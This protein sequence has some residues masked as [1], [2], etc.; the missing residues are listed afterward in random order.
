MIQYQG[1]L[2]LTEKLQDNICKSKYFK[3]VVLVKCNEGCEL[4]QSERMNLSVV[5]YTVEVNSKRILFNMQGDNI[6]KGSTNTVLAY[7]PIENRHLAHFKIMICEVSSHFVQGMINLAIETKQ[8][9]AYRGVL[10]KPLLIKNLKVY[11]KHM[12]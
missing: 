2:K 7:D 3:L 11:A 9:L 6:L 4:L 12:R 8:C 5:V 10:I 1:R